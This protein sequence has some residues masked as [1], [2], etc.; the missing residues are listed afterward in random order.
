[1]RRKNILI[2]GGCRGIGREIAQ[3]LIRDGHCVAITGSNPE[4]VEAARAALPEYCLALLADVTDSTATAATVGKVLDNFGRID[5]L[6][7]NA[8]ISGPGGL[9]WLTSPDDWW[10]V[11]EVNVGWNR[12]NQLLTVCSLARE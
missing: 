4:R 12:I 3:S 11:H 2:T 6:I 1:M 8:G 5:V 7:N 10:R 9:T